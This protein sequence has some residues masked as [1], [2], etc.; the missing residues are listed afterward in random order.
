MSQNNIAR[1]KLLVLSGYAVTMSMLGTSSG[2]ASNNDNA[3]S[4]DLVQPELRS[5]VD[6]LLVTQFNLAYAPNAIGGQDG[7]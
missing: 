6:G 4:T 5:S 7:G 2:S 1:R 3:L